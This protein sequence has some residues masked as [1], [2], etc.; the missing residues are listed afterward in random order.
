MAGSPYESFVDLEDYRNDEIPC[1]S[2]LTEKYRQRCYGVLF[3][4][5]PDKE[6]FRVQE[7][8]MTGAGSIDE[9][10]LRKIEQPPDYHP[11]L[12]VLWNSEDK[13]ADDLRYKLFHWGVLFLSLIHI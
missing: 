10:V 3:F 4:E 13:T 2:Q 6:D 12:E 5:R 11:G 8:C 9:V 1:S 7:W